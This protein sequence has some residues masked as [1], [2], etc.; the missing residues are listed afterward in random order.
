VPSSADQVTASDASTWRIVSSA[1][2][3]RQ[4]PP[5][6]GTNRQAVASR[7]G[8]SSAESEVADRR[9]VLV[10]AGHLRPERR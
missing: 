9:Q 5:A 1:Q 7:S 8:G 6:R 4:H 2:P 10:S 3:A